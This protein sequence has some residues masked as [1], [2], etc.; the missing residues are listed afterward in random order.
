MFARMI[1]ASVALFACSHASFA[2]QPSRQQLIPSYTEVKAAECDPCDRTAVI[3]VHGIGGDADTWKYDDKTNWPKLL[4]DD[5]AIGPKVDVYLVNY[6]SSLL[7]SE[8]SIVET[9]KEVDY[10][11]DDLFH[12]RQYKKITMICHSMGGILCRAYLLHVKARYGHRILSKFRLVFEMAVPHDGSPYANFIKLFS[13]SPEIRI[14]TTIDKDDFKQLMEQTLAE[15]LQKHRDQNCPTLSFY[16]GF[17]QLP[18]Q[19]NLPLIPW[20]VHGVIIVERR[21]A[22][23]HADKVAGFDKDHITLVKPT[24]VDDA[25][26]FWVRENL[27]ACIEGTTLC[28]G[29][30]ANK[31]FDQCGRSSDEFPI[32]DPVD[33]L[34]KH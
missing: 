13:A 29:D 22:I 26:Y 21:S 6:N 11:L 30:I 8:P 17:E 27:K 4:I 20:P 12:R 24:G 7:W 14:L 5:P 1:I 10:S 23:D 34:F 9:M 3:F 28:R 33:T 18:L 19:L 32:P 16:A 25:V 15:L 2:Q 31:E